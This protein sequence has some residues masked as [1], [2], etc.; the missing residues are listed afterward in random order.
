MIAPA[1]RKPIPVTICAA[2]RVG[3]AR[4]TFAPEVRNSLNP[5]AE[6][7][8][9]SAEPTDTS[10]CVRSPASR[11]RSSRSR[12]ST[13]PSAAAS[14]TRPRISAQ[15]REGILD[16]SS[17]SGFLLRRR[18][19]SDPD[20]RQLKKLVQA[21]ARERFLL[22]GRLHLDEPAVTGHDDVHVDLGA[23]ILR[24]VE[25]EQRL[26]VD[27]ADRNRR[28]RVAQRLREPEPVEGEA[29]S[30]PRAADRRTAGAAV[31]LQ[32]V[33]VEP[34]RPLAAR[35]EV[36]DRPQRAS[37]QAVDFDRPPAL[38][39]ARGLSLGAL[40]RR[41]RQERVLG[42]HPAAS[43]PLQPARDALFDRSG[44]EHLRL[45]L[46]VE[47][48]AVWLLEPA[49]LELDRAQLVRAPAVSSRHA[50]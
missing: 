13:A 39:A 30:S 20:R 21:L 34:E 44:A 46:G 8:V 49:R 40:A 10:R 31:R 43:L 1:P 16:A 2:I 28:D 50:A 47:H 17:T 38:P 26:G 6:T 22:G 27:D 37:E 4:T 7:I 29:R 48:R 15:E 32:H 35:L 5:Y 19:P 12:P 45:A 24:V 11:S 18:D 23:R 33:A 36:G 3:S 42:R 25:I 41:R 14:A 9:K